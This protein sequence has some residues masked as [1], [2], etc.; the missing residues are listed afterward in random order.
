MS[1]NVLVCWAW[2]RLHRRWQAGSR[3][4]PAAAA[5]PHRGLLPPALQGG[6]EGAAEHEGA[7]RHAE[8]DLRG[9]VIGLG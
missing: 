1:A 8:R 5:A 2:E 6:V 9:V 4:G 7:N 3:G